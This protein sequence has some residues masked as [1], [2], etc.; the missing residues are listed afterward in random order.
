M[1]SA[2]NTPILMI[3]QCGHCESSKLIFRMTASHGRSKFLCGCCVF[4]HKP[5]LLKSFLTAIVVGTILVSINAGNKIFIGQFPNDLYWKIPLT[6]CVPFLVATWGA[7]I[8]SKISTE[9]YFGLNS[10]NPETDPNGKKGN[11]PTIST[12]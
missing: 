7:L 11:V 8:N 4:K 1:T 5:L 12:I 6:Y 2:E 10:N 3:E 9:V